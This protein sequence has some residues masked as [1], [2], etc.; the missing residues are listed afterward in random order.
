MLRNQAEAFGF[1]DS[2]VLRDLP[3]ATSQF[4]AGDQEGP[5]EEPE[6]AL[7]SIGQADV[8]ASPLQMAMVV[9]GI[10]NAGTVMKPYVVA[11]VRAPNLDVL[12]TTAPERLHE[13]ITPDVA[14]ELTEM[15]EA[16]TA[17]GGTGTSAAMGDIPVAAKTG[18]AQTSDDRKPYAWFV[19]FAPADDPQIAVAVFIEDAAGVDREGISGGGLAGPIAKAMMEAVILR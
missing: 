19:S 6:V 16:V 3:S 12:D 5:L 18:T 7:T 8:A 11:E 13:A 14:A 1:G 9:A 15:M 17:P 2:D 10:A 4:T